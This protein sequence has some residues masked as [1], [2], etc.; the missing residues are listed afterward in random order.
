MGMDIIDRRL[1]ELLQE[2]ATMPIAELAARVN[3]SQTPCWKR[4]QRLKEAEKLGFGQAVLP[5]ASDDLSTG[6]GANAFQPSSL[7]DLVV[8]IAGSKRGRP[9]E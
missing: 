3:L 9:D 8:R 7:T 6:I 2:D 5:V 1:L 4:V